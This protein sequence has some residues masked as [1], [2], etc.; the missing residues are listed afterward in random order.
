MSLDTVVVPLPFG[1]LDASLLEMRS[2]RRHRPRTR[3]I[4]RPPD[5]VA[6]GEL[7]GQVR[8]V[9]SPEHKDAAGFAGAPR[10]RADASC[11]PRE[12]ADDRTMIDEWLRDAVRRGALGGRVSPLCVVQA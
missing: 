7:A 8:Y 1:I 2:P 10:L 12:V 4:V 6:L 9:G 3:E 11:C 5:G